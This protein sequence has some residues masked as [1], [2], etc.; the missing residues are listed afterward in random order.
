MY[1][2]DVPIVLQLNIN[3]HLFVFMRRFDAIFFCSF[4]QPKKRRKQLTVE[5]H[6][7]V[8]STQKTSLI[9]YVAHAH[10][11]TTI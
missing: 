8:W 1:E 7:F 10:D 5:W 3:N 2:I 6:P 9:L 11:N 4:A